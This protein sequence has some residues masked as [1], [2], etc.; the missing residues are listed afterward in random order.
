MDWIWV[1]C[2]IGGKQYT[3]TY[4]Y[5]LSMED[6]LEELIEKEIEERYEDILKYFKGYSYWT[7]EY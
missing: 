6:D 3:F 2:E 1:T 4:D 7:V 5:D